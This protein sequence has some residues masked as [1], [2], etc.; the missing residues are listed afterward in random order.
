DKLAAPR[1]GQP[2]IARERDA[3]ARALRFAIAAEDTPA[4]VDLRPGLSTCQRAGRAQLRA[5]LERGGILFRIEPGPAA[6]LLR[7]RRVE[8]LVVREPARGIG[9]GH[10]NDLAAPPLDQ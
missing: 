2:P 10:V 8:D 3:A 1:G 9:S 4:E 7:P 5:S 6:E